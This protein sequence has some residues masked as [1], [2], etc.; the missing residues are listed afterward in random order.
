MLLI[1]RAPCCLLQVYYNQSSDNFNNSEFYI[2][3]LP[4]DAI[5]APSIVA[6]VSLSLQ[7][8]Q[9]IAKPCCWGFS[10]RVFIVMLCIG[11]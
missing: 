11:F 2:N 5:E 7:V 4:V 1:Q 9:Q 10:V 8:G 3:I 6:G